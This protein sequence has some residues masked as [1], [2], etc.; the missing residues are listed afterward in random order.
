MPKIQQLLFPTNNSVVHSLYSTPTL[1]HTHSTVHSFFCTL[2]LLCTHSFVHPLY[3]TPTLLY[4]PALLYTRST[5]HLLYCTQK[6]T[7]LVSVTKINMLSIANYIFFPFPKGTQLLVENIDK[8][9]AGV[10]TC[11][12]QNSRGPVIRR[13]FTLEVKGTITLSLIHSLVLPM[14]LLIL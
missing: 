1:L 5:V 2:T 12:V 10:Y 14:F 11:H 7:M 8:H 6:I 4:T 3:C 9:H 13:H